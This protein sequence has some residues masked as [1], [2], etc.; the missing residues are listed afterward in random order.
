MNR[1]TLSLIVALSL[2]GCASPTAPS[3]APLPETTAPPQTI[4][5]DGKP[6][7]ACAGQSNAVAFCSNT[8]QIEGWLVGGLYLETYAHVVGDWLG[9]QPIAMWDAP[10]GALW[11]A[12][13]TSLQTTP[14]TAF[15]WWQ[16]ENDSLDGV[17]GVYLAAL[18]NLIARVRQ[19]AHQPQLV[20]VIVE[21]GPFYHDRAIMDDQRQFVARDG[22]ALYINTEDLLYPDGVHMD[23]ASYQAVAAR[24]AQQINRR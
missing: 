6:A 9:G 5:T 14:V 10:D 12:L 16:G 4:F 1:L 18:Q 11:P 24:I 17:P 2:T 7:W 19:A 13:E 20:T 15:V 21:L 8:D 22:H 3:H 23:A